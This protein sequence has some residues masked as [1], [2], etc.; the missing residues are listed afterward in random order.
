M[1]RRSGTRGT[2]ADGTPFPIPVTL[3]VSP[4]AVPDAAGQ[5]L[6]ADPEGTP[7]AL[8]EITGR[9]EV[10]APHQAAADGT[11]LVRLCGPVTAD[12]EPEHGPFRRLMRPPAEVRAEFGDR[13][14]ARLRQPRPAARPADRPA[15]AHGRPAEGAA[16]GAPAGRRSGRGGD[17]TRGADPGDAR[18]RGEPA[19]GDAGGSRAA[20]PPGPRR[21]PGQRAGG[22]GAGRRGLR[23][24]PPDGRTARPRPAADVAAPIPVVPRGRLGL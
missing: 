2:L 4:D 12:R 15:P 13:P 24:H 10:T 16:A 7:L 19:A 11:R 8:L 21:Q 5:V 9:S 6:L 17:Q 23:R 22:A 18:R 3:D 1:S 14:G 20:G